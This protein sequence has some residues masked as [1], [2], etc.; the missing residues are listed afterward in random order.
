MSDGIDQNNPNPTNAILATVIIPARNASDCIED[1]MKAL[2][3]QSV[4][5]NRYQIILV[6]DG[7]SDD[8][9]KRAEPYCDRVIRIAPSGP[10]SA[11]NSGARNA[12]GS[13][14]LFTDA[15]CQPEQD[16]IGKML[17]PFQDPAVHGV[18]GIY[19]SKQ[20][21][22]IARFVQV[23]YEGKYQFMSRY[24]SI[25]FIDTYSAGFRRDTFLALGGFDES[26]PG[27]SVEDQEFSFRMH[28]AGYRMIFTPAA[29]VLHRHAD[30]W[31]KYFLKKFKIGFW[32]VYVLQKHPEKIMSDTHTP[33][34]LKAQ[35]PLSLLIPV[36]LL[37][38]PIIGYLPFII[39]SVLFIL[40]G[41]QE[42]RNCVRK[43]SYQLAITAP[44]IML[45][46]SWAL[47]L[48]LIQGCALTL[49]SKSSNGTRILG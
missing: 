48:G 28:K 31:K 49:I 41:F 38:S 4:A 15:D 33:P 3:H 30:H 12:V 2:T 21:Q 43:D 25:D 37:A 5:R 24:E 22:L 23:E 19:R 17:L 11:R 13:I 35:I 27:A 32:K 36:V 7:S 39:F 8:T 18:K 29:I 47:G 44:F 6:D 45:L 42:I 20:Q 9:A 40:A 46:R 16:W 26:F 1:C 34:T 10:A 14:L